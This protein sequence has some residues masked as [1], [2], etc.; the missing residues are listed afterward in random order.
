MKYSIDAHDRRNPG[1]VLERNVV[2]LA[3]LLVPVVDA[4]DEGRDERDAGLGAGDGLGEGKQ[5]GQ[6]AVDALFLE[7]LG[8]ADALPGAGDLDQDAL[9]ANPGLGVEG[10]QLFGLDH[11][12]LGVEGK[13]GVDL[14]RYPPGD[15]FKDFAPEAD[16][17][18]VDHRLRIGAGLGQ[19][20]VDQRAVARVLRR[21]E[22]QRRIGGRVLR[23]PA[24]DGV[25][26]AG[27]GNDD[28]VR[29]EGVELC[30]HGRRRIPR[31]TPIR[32]MG[33]PY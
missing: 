12:R 13:S 10:D 25:D 20:G 32:P 9:R 28:G 2:D 19:G 24:C 23:F 14:G 26:I 15:V 17:K 11:G 8:G 21:G 18:L 29:F 27:V 33:T 31:Q 4:A 3:R 22:E 7:P 30:G 6:V 1:I 5:Q 16:E